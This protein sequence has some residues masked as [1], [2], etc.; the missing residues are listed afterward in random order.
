MSKTAQKSRSVV[1]CHYVR[2]PCYTETAVPQNRLGKVKIS[3]PV[4]SRLFMERLVKLKYL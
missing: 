4:S 3:L 1:F 2:H